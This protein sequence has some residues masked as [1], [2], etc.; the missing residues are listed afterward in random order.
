MPARPA[1]VMG[2]ED[3]SSCSSGYSTVIESSVRAKEPA[4]AGSFLS[5]LL[6]WERRVELWTAAALGVARVVAVVLVLVR[7]E[8]VV[9]R[10][11]VAAMAGR[12]PTARRAEAAAR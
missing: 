4:W 5:L 2:S 9:K 6:A 10:E 7:K 11:V 3:G 8:K 12:R 1:P